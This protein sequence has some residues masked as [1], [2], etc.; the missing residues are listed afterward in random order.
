M[1]SPTFFKTTPLYPTQENN[2]GP[3]NRTATKAKR[4]GGNPHNE[5]PVQGDIAITYGAS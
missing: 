4:K 1:F 2:I 5:Q 3:I